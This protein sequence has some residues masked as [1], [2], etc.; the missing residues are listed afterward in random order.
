MIYSFFSRKA[1]VSVAEEMN[2]MIRQPS[3]FSSIFL[4]LRFHIFCK[5]K[6]IQPGPEGN[7]PKV[8]SW[9][10][11]FTNPTSER[12]P[13]TIAL[14]CRW[15]HGKFRNESTRF[16]K[17]LSKKVSGGAEISFIFYF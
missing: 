6:W 13:S 12:D 14:S 3:T 9:E 10:K 11:G 7:A 2:E 5:S 1:S 8:A 17:C 4:F 15:I 16:L